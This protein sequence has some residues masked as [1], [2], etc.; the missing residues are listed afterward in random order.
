[1]D[2]YTETDKKEDLD[3]GQLELMTKS[4]HSFLIDY[5]QHNTRFDAHRIRLLL[6][7][8]QVKAKDMLE[9]L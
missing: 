9:A 4:D 6:E 2:T 8:G 7:L 3:A 5:L 1:M